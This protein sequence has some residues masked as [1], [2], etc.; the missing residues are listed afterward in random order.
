M[1][2]TPGKSIEEASASFVLAYSRIPLEMLEQKLV[3]IK[4]DQKI[5]QKALKR[6]ELELMIMEYT[7][8]ILLAIMSAGESVV[9]QRAV[10]ILTTAKDVVDFA[11]ADNKTNFLAGYLLGKG[12]D[13]MIKNGTKACLMINPKTLKGKDK[14]YFELGVYA[15]SEIL[16]KGVVREPTGTFTSKA[17]VWLYYIH[18]FRCQVNSVYQKKFAA[19]AAFEKKLQNVPL[20]TL[21]YRTVL[22]NPSAGITSPSAGTTNQSMTPKPAPLIY[23]PLTPKKGLD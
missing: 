13:Q 23:I 9:L 21:T 1:P 11:E 19:A 4:N 2:I 20:S 17:D 10:L 5:K 16:K 3:F 22:N 18:Q 8:G 12:L 6:A 15:Q 7:I 14:A